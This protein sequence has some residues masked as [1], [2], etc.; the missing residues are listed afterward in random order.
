[1]RG[2]LGNE[3]PYRYRYPS[4]YHS[5]S[6]LL[7]LVLLNVRTV[8]EAVLIQVNVGFVAVQGQL[9]KI[10]LALA[11][12]TESVFNYFDTKPRCLPEDYCETM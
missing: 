2:A 9:I 10:T 5:V 1:M 11:A 6:L 4:M 3:C 7:E 8:T 12:L